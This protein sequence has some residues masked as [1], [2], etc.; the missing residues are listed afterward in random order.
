MKSSIFSFNDCSRIPD[1]LFD[2]YKDRLPS[3]EFNDLIDTVTRLQATHSIT[4]VKTHNGSFLFSTGNDEERNRIIT[5]L[6]I[7]SQEVDKARSA[8][9]TIKES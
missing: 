2:A 9:K 7:I 1:E 5:R 3:Y 4:L 6:T 8:I